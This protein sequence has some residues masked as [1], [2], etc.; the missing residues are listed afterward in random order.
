MFLAAI[1]V[2][3]HNS[4]HHPPGIDC[5]PPLPLLLICLSRLLGRTGDRI[6]NVQNGRL[7]RSQDRVH[8]ESIHGTAKGVLHVT[9]CT[10]IPSPGRIEK[11]SNRIEKK[12]KPADRPAS[13]ASGDDAWTVRA[14][15]LSLH[16]SDRSID[17]VPTG[18]D[19]SSD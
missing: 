16:R 2:G 1:L 3:Y 14:S 15:L 4:L 11:K 5:F 17:R 18:I 10:A 9:G 12:K 7:L 8:A 19:T 13:M 6:D